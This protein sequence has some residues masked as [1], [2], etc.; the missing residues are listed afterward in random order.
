MDHSARRTAF[1]GLSGSNRDMVASDTSIPRI[2]GLMK[3]GELEP[4]LYGEYSR[5]LQSGGKSNRYDG[6]RLAILDGSFFSHIQ[7]NV[8]CLLSGDIKI[9]VDLEIYKKRGKELPAGKELLRRMGQNLGKN[10]VDIVLY[11]GLGFG[12]EMFRIVN[13]SLGAHLLVKTKEVRLDICKEID[14]YLADQQFDKF[15]IEKGFD[16][17]RMERYEIYQAKWTFHLRGYDK[18]L[19]AA[20][21]INTNIKTG[22]VE[23]RY[24]ITSHPSLSPKQ[25]RDFA[26]ARW[27]IENNVFKMLNRIVWTKHAYTGNYT[28]LKNML[29]IFFMA[30][31]VLQN[32]FQD[33]VKHNE[34]LKKE[35]GSKNKWTFIGVVQILASTVDMSLSP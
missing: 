34:N 20:K 33:E 14:F 12:A 29:L 3:T 35:M 5:I 28:V 30:Y 18:P 32:Y 26:I 6:F 23:I 31:L 17:E 22:E 1:K 4:V 15:D 25:M 24:V 16:T 13:E 9:P 21:V 2:L 19:Y 11:D 10:A 27:Q 8:A 7:A